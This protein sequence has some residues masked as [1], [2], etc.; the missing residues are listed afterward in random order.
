MNKFCESGL[1]VKK[2][3][4]YVL[5]AR[6]GEPAD[7]IGAFSKSVE[8]RQCCR[9]HCL[10]VLGLRNKDLVQMLHAVPGTS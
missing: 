8:L 1:C 6:R 4:S 2:V 7:A 10:R 5:I 3:G 9:R